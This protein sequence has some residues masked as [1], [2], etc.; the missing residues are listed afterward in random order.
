MREVTDADIPGLQLALE[1]C[2]SDADR[3]WL[4]DVLNAYEIERIERLKPRLTIT[5]APKQMWNKS[6]QYKVRYTGNNEFLDVIFFLSPTEWPTDE[7]I[8]M[9][10]QSEC[11]KRGLQ[12]AHVL[13]DA[14]VVRP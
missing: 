11:Y 10:V 9:K 14:E 7:V 4:T 1:H 8:R 3:Q 13:L 6:W 2:T 12:L 5:S